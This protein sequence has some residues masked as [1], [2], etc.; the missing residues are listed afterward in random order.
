MLEWDGDLAGVCEG[1]ERTNNPLSHTRPS[2]DH[3]GM[4][5]GMQAGGTQAGGPVARPSA[6]TAA[7]RTDAAASHTGA[8]ESHKGAAP[9]RKGAG[10]APT[11]GP[12]GGAK[13]SPML[14]AEHP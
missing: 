13:P 4:Q 14:N 1:V 7:S 5:A 8:A 12:G 6:H 9:A 11:A 3:A 2:S 10:P